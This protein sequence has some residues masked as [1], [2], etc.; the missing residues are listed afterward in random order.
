MIEYADWVVLK[1]N[2]DLIPLTAEAIGNL[3]KNAN[4]KSLQSVFDMISKSFRENIEFM[5]EKFDF[6]YFILMVDH[7]LTDS[8]LKFRH[9]VL[10]DSDKYLISHNYGKNF[11]KLVFAIFSENVE[12]L[13]HKIIDLIVED[14][15]L[16]FKIKKIE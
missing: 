12:K 11:S 1:K 16:S 5:Y 4:E 2:L 15:K 6:H 10:E 13:E 9:F 14:E 8:G 7:W 3:L